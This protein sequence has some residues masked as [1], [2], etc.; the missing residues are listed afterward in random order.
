MARPLFQKGIGSKSCMS[1]TLMCVPTLPH[2][3]WQL[4]KT[5]QKYSLHKLH[6]TFVKVL[7]SLNDLSPVCISMP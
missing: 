7:E 3:S 2:V 5:V 1:Q 6:D 4:D